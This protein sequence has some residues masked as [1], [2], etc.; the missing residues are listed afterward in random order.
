MTDFSFTDLQISH[1]LVALRHYREM[2]LNLKFSVV[3]GIRR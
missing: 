3:R 1:L 2:L